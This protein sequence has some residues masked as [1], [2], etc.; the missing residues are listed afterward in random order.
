MYNFITYS[1]EGRIGEI[2]I[3]KPPYNVLDIKTMDEINSA[4]DDVKK[5]ER[6]L[7]VL[8]ITAEGEKAFS[9]GVDVADHT[10]DKMELM[11]DS[12]HGIFRRLEML[13]IITVAG[14]KGSA[15]GGGC[16]LAIGCDLIVC[17]DN[18]KFGQPEIKLAVF[19]P[20]AITYLTQ[21]VGRKRAFEI[22]ILGENISA[23]EAKAMG[24]VNQVFPLQEF[25]EKLRVYLKKF[26]AMSGSALKVTKQAFKKSLAFDFERTLSNAEAMYVKDLMSLEDANEGINSFLEKRK[27]IWKNR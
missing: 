26:E 2:K 21:V 5:S 20:I 13:D 25:D 14:V 27:P 8:L 3:N 4:L 9:A 17:A 16:E 1:K 10:K 15:L 22:V 6:D 12:F 7:N 11:L 23:E 19:P 24:L 18:A